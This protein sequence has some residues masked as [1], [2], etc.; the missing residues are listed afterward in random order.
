MKSPRIVRAIFLRLVLLAC[1]SFILTGC[2][3]L[4]R[5][6]AQQQQ[7]STKPG[8][9]CSCRAE[10]QDLV[11]L[12]TLMEVVNY[13]HYSNTFP[14]LPIR[15]ARGPKN[16]YAFTS[17]KENDHAIYFVTANFRVDWNYN[18]DVIRHEMAHAAAGPDHH[19]A[20]WEREYRRLRGTAASARFN[21]VRA[22]RLASQ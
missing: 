2:D 1:V 16:Y 20:V 13:T 6:D 5:M 11:A 7:Q 15:W 21:D 9:G 8:P 3:R 17:F 22:G 4:L 12:T 19:D 14:A 18:F 10:E